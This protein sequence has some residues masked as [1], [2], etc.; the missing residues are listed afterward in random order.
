MS[1]PLWQKGLLLM[2]IGPLV[3]MVSGFV[4]PIVGISESARGQRF[5]E[6]LVTYLCV[7]AGVVLVSMHFV[8]GIRDSKVRNAEKRA[9]SNAGGPAVRSTGHDGRL[10]PGH[11]TAIGW[12]V[13][14]L[15]VVASIAI[16]I[17]VF[18]AGNRTDVPR[19]GPGVTESPES[20]KPHKSYPVS[21]DIPEDSQVV[22]SDATL[23]PGT[24]L[25]ACWAGK[26]N[27]NTLLSENGD[28]NR[29]VRWDD[30]GPPY[31]CR[32]VRS[33]LIIRRDV[34][35][36]FGEFPAS[37]PAVATPRP[38]AANGAAGVDPKPKSL[39]NCPVTIGVPAD[40][41]VVPADAKLPPGTR[42]QAC[43]SGK[44]NPITLLSEDNDGNLTVRWNDFGP[45]FD[46]SMIRKELI[47]K[48]DVLKHRRRR[49][50]RHQS[51]L[52]A[53]DG[54]PEMLAINAARLRSQFVRYVE[55]DLFQW[56]PTEQFDTVCCSDQNS[57]CSCQRMQTEMDDQKVARMTITM[58]STLSDSGTSA[59]SEL[60]EHN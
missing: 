10:L 34:L 54:S 58:T 39:K 50:E 48:T 26:W 12:G 19:P 8:R 40:S 56:R 21:I 52:T 46:C 37:P 14:G 49:D 30:F 17:G 25:Q 15:C 44:W 16:L 18:V 1:I 43:W 7:I 38:K 9:K 60:P 31:D 47:I 41:H 27:P 45:P 23:P 28:G 53:L 36:Q 5:E 57:S 32:M 59:K 6:G 4:F 22:P 33:E 24:R 20:K 35:K 51:H 13:L 55:A 42:L 3:N 11:Y 2:V 29:T